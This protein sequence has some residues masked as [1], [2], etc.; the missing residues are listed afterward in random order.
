MA[1]PPTAPSRPGTPAFEAALRG[2]DRRQVDEFIAAGRSEVAQL[3]AELAEARRQQ[4]S[5]TEHAE[6]TEQPDL[7]RVRDA[8]D[9]MMGHFRT[10][11]NSRFGG[12]ARARAAVSLRRAP[13]R[14]VERTARLPGGTPWP[15]SHRR[16]PRTRPLQRRR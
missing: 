7:E 9:L 8:H 3:Q 16:R 10:A 6:A 15:T 2:Y 14:T 11:R 5:A 1:T 4:R 13:S 12:D